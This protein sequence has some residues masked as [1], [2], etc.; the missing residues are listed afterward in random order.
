MIAL[1]QRVK[2]QTGSNLT[3]TPYGLLSRTGTPDIL[4]FY[5]LH[6]GLIG[7]LN[8]VLEEVDYDDVREG[9]K[10]DY[11]TTGGWL[12]ITDKYWLAALIPDQKESF[13]AR[14][15]AGKRG[16]LDLYQSDYLAQ[17]RNVPAGGAANYTTH[18]FAG[19]KE[20]K[21]LDTYQEAYSIPLFD[22]A[23]DFGWFYFLTKPIFYALDWLYDFL[24]NF[25]LAILALTV[26]IK[27][28]F[29]PLA[30]KSYKSMSKMKLLQP[31]M[32]ELRDKYGEDKQRLNQEMMALY[33][34][35]GANPA[36][37]CLPIVIQIPVF[38]ALYKVLFVN[39]E[40]RQAP[41]YGWI[42]DLSAPDPLGLLTAFGLISWNVPESLAIVNIG[43]WPLIMGI[44]MFL[45]QKL[46][47]DTDGPGPGQDFHVYADHLHL[48]AGP[49]PGRSGDLLGLEQHSVDLAAMGHHAAAR[50]QRG[51][52]AGGG[53]C[54]RVERGKNDLTGEFTPEEI[55]AGRHLFAQQCEFRHGRGKPCQECRRT[56]C[57]KLRLPAGPTS[58]SRV[59]STRLPVERPSPARATR[60]AERSNSTSST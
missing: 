35:E 39:I 7:V 50:R 15:I 29:F 22:K 14:F 38:F 3:L 52:R 36:A 37:G 58:E 17:P 16:A 59:S 10:Y 8:D 18:L 33:K 30:N 9:E 54:E 21:L 12:G 57:R 28:V 47:P 48:P 40:M 46:K 34:K 53:H 5:I 6:E 25:G 31:K 42:H 26:G 41:F 23:V 44:T 20:V 51:R 60:R 1:T 43:I 2:N 27:L 4:G 19:A 55:E 32:V 56:I 24:G 49:V 45:Q 11:I 13:K